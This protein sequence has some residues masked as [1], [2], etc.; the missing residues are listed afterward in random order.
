MTTTLR[1]A[2]PEERT[3]DGGRSRAFDIRVNGRDAGSLRLS[4][5]R[6][7]GRVDHLEVAAP[8]RRRGRATVAVLAAEEALR[9]WGCHEAEASVP[10]TAD[11]ALTL[12]T[13]L[14]Y[15]ERNRHLV[16]HLTDP[17]PA[18]PPGSA[19][20]DMT[21]AEFPAWRDAARAASAR[22]WSGRGRAPAAAEARA[23]RA[24]ATLLPD[25]PA[26]EDAVLRVLTH[27]GADAG[28]LWVSLDT[29]RLR[30]GEDAYVYE[31]EVAPEH[32]GRGHGR[33][34]MREAE[35]ICRAAGA[36]LLGLNV[37]AGNTPALRLYASLG[38]EP[39]EIHFYKS[40][41]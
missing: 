2:G 15:T 34:L 24:Y 16:K 8:D 33:T 17:V 10:A 3:A 36:R 20:R 6:G 37:F 22:S 18:P 40:L 14:G 13:A 38:Y 4:A 7:T 26:T 35:R 39:V 29:G 27:E 41:G 9:A 21:A 19:L 5:T 28:T 31:V 12:A 1:P 23:E 11:G 32:R 30:H 25:G